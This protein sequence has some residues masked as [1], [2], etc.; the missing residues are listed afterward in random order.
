MEL[1]KQIESRGALMPLIG[2]SKKPL[3]KDWTT[4]S[5]DELQSV[6]RVN[7]N[8]GLRLDALVHFDYDFNSAR[9]GKRVTNIIDRIA[10][11]TIKITR[12][13]RVSASL[14]PADVVETQNAAGGTILC[15]A[16][17]P[18][19]T[20]KDFALTGSDKFEIRFS[21]KRQTMIPPSIHKDKR[22]HLVWETNGI[23]ELPDCTR[24][25][26]ILESVTAAIVSHAAVNS[27]NAKYNMLALDV[28]AYLL[29][30]L[31]ADLSEDLLCR[32]IESLFTELGDSSAASRVAECARPTYVK[33]SGGETI[34]ARH[35]LGGDTSINA[36][37]DGIA[38]LFAISSAFGGRAASPHTASVKRARIDVCRRDPAW[39]AVL[40]NSGGSAAAL[41]PGTLFPNP[42]GPGFMWVRLNNGVIRIDKRSTNMDLEQAL[43]YFGDALVAG[44]CSIDPLTLAEGLRSNSPRMRHYSGACPHAGQHMGYVDTYLGTRAAHEPQTGD[45]KRIACGINAWML[46][47]LCGSSSDNY[48][49]LCSVLKQRREYPGRPPYSIIVFAGREGRTGKTTGA[50]LCAHAVLAHPETNLTSTSRGQSGLTRFSGSLL[51][52]S[53]LLLDEVTSRGA[54][55]VA[56]WNQLTSPT[57][58]IERKGV[59]PYSIPNCMQVIV[60]TNYLDCLPMRAESNSQHR[61][62]LL[63]PKPWADAVKAREYLVKGDAAAG[64]EIPSA[65]PSVKEYTG[66]FSSKEVL[67]D[68]VASIA[69]YVIDRDGD[70]NGGA[71]ID[72]PGSMQPT[73]DEIGKSTR[74]A[75]PLYF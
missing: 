54:I 62:L 33:W 55:D 57:V 32:Y 1:I 3:M 51:D 4:L 24:A 14:L 68:D 43:A 52:N 44:G 10:E 36:K 5:K 28:S 63:R 18:H 53:C 23:I 37:D 22:E 59:Q 58:E 48:K 61:Y 27:L 64:V 2:E 35:Y 19:A 67:R 65:I 25:R 8:T 74:R 50:T 46:H 21:R 20:S 29:G 34:S 70:S 11:P 56:M 6:S 42:A 15:V 9:L 41:S 66:W 45:E 40:G 12:N 38:G 30:L 13:G 39:I 75:D 60:T 31:K 7:H 71:R 73:A 47:V 17:L 72:I 69:A 49:A 16:G 26:A